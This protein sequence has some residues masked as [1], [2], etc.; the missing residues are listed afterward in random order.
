MC[1]G[2]RVAALSGVHADGERYLA[3]ML[4]GGELLLRLADGTAAC[5]QRVH[6]A[7]ACSECDQ[8]CMQQHAQYTLD[9]H[10]HGHEY[11]A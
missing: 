6:A 8:A 11:A 2:W 10:E 9:E 5:M 3:C 7:S 1:L 4:E